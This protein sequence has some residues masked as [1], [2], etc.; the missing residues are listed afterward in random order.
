MA[1]ISTNPKTQILTRSPNQNRAE[2]WVRRYGAGV[3]LVFLMLLGLGLRL[4]RLD[5][6]L[7]ED[8]I[9]N[10]YSS[11]YPFGQIIPHLFPDHTPLFFFLSHLALNLFGYGHNPLTLRLPAMLVGVLNIPAIYWLGRE[12]TGRTR[13]AL[14][15]ATLATF[16]PL[17][18]SMSQ[19]Y[20]MYSLLVLLTVLSLVF[21]LR[22]LR[23]N[24]LLDW[25][26]FVLLTVLNLYNHYNA[27]FVTGLEAAFCIIWLTIPVCKNITKR[28]FHSPSTINQKFEWRVPIMTSLSFGC[29]AILYL[30]WLPHFFKFVRTAG[31]GTNLV[32]Q[33]ASDSNSFYEFV[34]RS[35]FGFGPGLGLSLPVPQAAFWLTLPLLLFGLSVLCVERFYYGLFCACYL[36]GGWLIVWLL[37]NSQLFALSNRYLCFITPVFLI[38]VAQGLAT[39]GTWSL[40]SL[41]K[42][43]QLPRR[44]LPVMAALPVLLLTVLIFEQAAE[45]LDKAYSRQSGINEAGAFLQQNLQP[46]DTLLAMPGPGSDYSLV[47]STMATNFAA[48]PDARATQTSH[49]YLLVFDQNTPLSALQTLRFNTHTLWL[50][51]YLSSAAVAQQ[52]LRQQISQ[53]ATN[54]FV[55]HCYLEVCLIGHRS[56]H[57]TTPYAD[58]RTIFQN[59]GFL[60]PQVIQRATRLLNFDLNPPSVSFNQPKTIILAK[61]PA[62][63]R[64]PVAT[65]TKVVVYYVNFKYKG[66]PTRIF[67]GA[68]DAIDTNLAILPGWSGYAP[69]P[70]DLNAADWPT[71]GLYFEAPPG[72]DHA[73]L[74]LLGENG[75]G[76]AQISDI[77]LFQ[78]SP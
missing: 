61:E 45:V 51:V 74:T 9:T 55:I 73:I 16:T 26:G 56:D 4:Y 11:I 39:V 22:A 24:H 58:L 34:S 6:P 57:T 65:T 75:S 41:A 62:Y 42:F 5:Y 60:N 69:P 15:T 19:Y 53:A 72:T 25:G 21:L 10:Y 70:T 77:Q 18:I 17:L 33:P 36:G 35:L 27:V 14:G 40:K 59:F 8:E 20:R 50:A 66:A 23:T 2:D 12:I 1:T 29:I 64:L 7:L 3:G 48:I 67:V 54:Q 52:N 47:Y 31:Y 37:P 38:G 28:R 49:D 13:V 44:F 63:V 68:Q 30:P 43:C 76:T 32:V 46:G 71:A 78:L